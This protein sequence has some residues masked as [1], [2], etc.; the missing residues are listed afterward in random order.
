MVRNI[1]KWFKPDATAR[2]KEQTAAENLAEVEATIDR[3][4]DEAGALYVAGSGNDRRLSEIEAELRD[5][6]PR[7]EWLQ[8]ARD[9]AAA[10]AAAE[11]AAAEAERQRL[12]A[13]EK[14]LRIAELRARHEASATKIAPAAL[15][16]AE[17]AKAYAASAA[18]LAREIDTQKLSR[19]SRAPLTEVARLLGMPA[20]RHRLSTTQC[21]VLRGWLPLPYELGTAPEAK[22]DLAELEREIVAELLGERNDTPATPMPVVRMPRPLLASDD[23]PEAA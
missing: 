2:D 15:A 19:S 1:L 22:R 3:L 5:L 12:A 4:N 21:S 13:E 18:E 16:F 23:E 8:R 14:R 11:E 20:L 6:L 17:A 9:Q 7:R 10:Q